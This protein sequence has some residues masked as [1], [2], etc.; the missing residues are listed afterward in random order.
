M[1]AFLLVIKNVFDK[2]IILIIY[3][4]TFHTKYIF[5]SFIIKFI[6]DFLV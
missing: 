2:N 1:P 4:K 3:K 6:I 5:L